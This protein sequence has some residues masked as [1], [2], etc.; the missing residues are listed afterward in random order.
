MRET[1]YE[2]ENYGWPKRYNN[3][4]ISSSIKMGENGE[5]RERGKRNTGEIERVERIRERIREN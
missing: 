1:K 4:G 5:S 3:Q 2:I